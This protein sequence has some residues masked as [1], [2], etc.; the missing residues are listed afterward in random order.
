MTLTAL[1]FST[2]LPLYSV[3]RVIADGLTYGGNLSHTLVNYGLIAVTTA[4]FLLLE[5][6]AVAV[7]QGPLA[8]RWAECLLIALAVQVALWFGAD[9]V[10]VSVVWCAMAGY[11]LLA[12]TSASEAF[13]PARRTLLKIGFGGALVGV[14]YYGA[15]FPVITTVAHGAALAMGLGTGPSSACCRTPAI[16]QAEPPD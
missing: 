15:A 1:P 10:G 2:A 8:R 3:A 7:P 5:D 11:G 14:L 12:L 6:R 16:P 4:P 13:G 9:A